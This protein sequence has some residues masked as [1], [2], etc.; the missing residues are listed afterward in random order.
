[1]TLAD[2]STP[3]GEPAGVAQ[4]RRTDNPIYN[5][6]SGAPQHDFHSLRRPGNV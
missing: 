1:M 4:R 3:E 2:T 5:A 6:A